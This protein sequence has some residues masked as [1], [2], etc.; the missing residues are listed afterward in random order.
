MLL[1][2]PGWPGFPE[3]LPHWR[4]V[5]AVDRALSD[6]GIPPGIVRADRTGREHGETMYMVLVWDVSRTGVLGGV[7]LNWEEETGWRTASWQEADLALPPRHSVP[8][9][10][11]P[12][13]R[14]TPPGVRLAR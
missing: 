6:R 2:P 11:R 8:Q 14:G 13:P 4:Y 10:D 3:A 9:G 12:G 1:D 5:Q 7:R